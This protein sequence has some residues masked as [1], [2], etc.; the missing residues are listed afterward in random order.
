MRRKDATR[1][2]SNRDRPE[3][4]LFFLINFFCPACQANDVVLK[5]LTALTICLISPILPP[6]FFRLISAGDA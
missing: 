3:A 6:P 1:N 2:S 5:Y 4:L